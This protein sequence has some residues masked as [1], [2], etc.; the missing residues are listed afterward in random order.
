MGQKPANQE[1]GKAAQAA[2][3]RTTGKQADPDA[4]RV[5]FMVLNPG[6]IPKSPRNPGSVSKLL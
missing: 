2:G 1:P 4:L 5:P 3:D 6:H